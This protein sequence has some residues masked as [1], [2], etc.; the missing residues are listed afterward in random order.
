MYFRAAQHV[1]SI[2]NVARSCCRSHQHSI[3]HSMSLVKL[4]QIW[5]LS[6]WFLRL[7]FIN[8]PIYFH[9][10]G[11]IFH[12]CH[13]SY[14]W[15]KVKNIWRVSFFNFTLVNQNAWIMQGNT[16]ITKF[17]I[18]SIH[19]DPKFSLH[20]LIRKDFVTMWSTY[21]RVSWYS[22]CKLLVKIYNG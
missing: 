10:N 7:D 6:T 20:F 4:H 13:L 17:S 12:W 16:V 15:M 11:N 22:S 2:C 8:T 14:V 9:F 19:L 1:C 21:D 3:W 5:C 18:S